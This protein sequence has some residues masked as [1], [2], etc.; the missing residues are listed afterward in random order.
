[1]KAGDGG[2]PEAGK[3]LNRDARH[4]DNPHDGNG[5]P[6]EQEESKRD[7][8]GNAAAPVPGKRPGAK[9]KLPVKA[10]DRKTA[11]VFVPRV[12]HRTG[13][14]IED[15]STRIAAVL[16]SGDQQAQAKYVVEDSDRAIRF[17]RTRPKATAQSVSVVRKYNDK[18]ESVDIYEFDYSKSFFERFDRKSTVGKSFSLLS[19]VALNL[20]RLTGSLI[21]GRTRSERGWRRAGVVAGL[22]LVALTIMYFYP[23]PRAN[24]PWLP[25]VLGI[26]LATA[27]LFGAWGK[28]SLGIRLTALVGGAAAGTGTSILVSE[29]QTTR[30]DVLASTLLIGGVLSLTYVL[31]KRANP[32]LGERVQMG[33][34]FFVLALFATYG[35]LLLGAVVTQVWDRL[36]DDGTDAEVAEALADPLTGIAL[37]A[38]AIGGTLVPKKFRRQMNDATVQLL[39]ATKYLSMGE[40]R[41]AEVGRLYEL[42][43]HLAE[44]GYKRIDIVGYSFGTVLALDALYPPVDGKVPGRMI[45]EV[46]NLVTIGCPAKTIGT[47]WPRYWE[48]RDLSWDGRWINIYSPHDVLSSR[49][50]YETAAG[51]P[52]TQTASVWLTP[53]NP[54]EECPLP[55]EEDE[56]SFNTGPN[57]ED[58]SSGQKLFLAGLRAH[59]SYWET[60]YD[61]DRGAVALCADIWK[62]GNGAVEDV[63]APGAVTGVTETEDALVLDETPEPQPEDT[64]TRVS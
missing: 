1:M 39:G 24:W 19:T 22:A 29:S 42:I 36:D 2:K 14:S 17:G 60:V 3:A 8:E 50:I 53:K 58:L 52:D 15:L 59:D 13:E 61:H 16:D 9:K 40:G 57:T 7:K 25:P 4:G 12:G 34:A 62:R 63:A 47:F 55:K 49:F 31:L 10:D 54:D 30:I 43:E 44:L 45:K 11:I 18:Q 32:D 6:R 33:I 5:N 38:T 35:V 56:L 46:E 28:T 51:G 21:S 27:V 37:V 20:G 64:D 41:D 26:A 48:N 23:E